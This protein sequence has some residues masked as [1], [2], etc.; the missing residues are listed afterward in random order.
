MQILAKILHFLGRVVLA[1]C[2]GIV[3]TVK[4]SA[5]YIIKAL[6]YC[7]TLLERAMPY[8]L[9]GL[10][11]AA[12]WIIK[13]IPKVIKSILYIVP[14]LYNGMKKTLQSTKTYIKKTYTKI[15]QKKLQKQQSKLKQNNH[16]VQKNKSKTQ[17]KTNALTRATTKINN[18]MN[19]KA[20]ETTATIGAI[21]ASGI[22]FDQIINSGQYALPEFVLPAAAAGTGTYIIHKIKQ[23][24]DEKKLALK[25]ATKKIKNYKTTQQGNKQKLLQ[26]KKIQSCNV[27]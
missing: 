11:K 19:K 14:I 4:Y 24:I 26:L 9:K 13:S 12:N 25:K 2:R 10:S 1:I 17:E 20:L 16:T 6:K 5:P 22:A 23:K 3:K 27:K 18:K 15:K 8:I 7:I 21:S